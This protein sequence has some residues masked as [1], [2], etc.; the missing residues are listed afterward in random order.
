MSDHQFADQEL[1]AN[2]ACASSLLKEG[3]ADGTREASLDCLAKKLGTLHPTR[4]WRGDNH[5][6]LAHQRQSLLRKQLARI[7][8]DRRAAKGVL[9]GH[10]IVHLERHHAIG[11]GSF[12]QNGKISGRDRIARLRL[13]VLARIG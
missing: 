1:A 12:E 8:M 13:P 5:R 2:H 4:V 10:D 3:A 11:A 9:K 6:L 7:E